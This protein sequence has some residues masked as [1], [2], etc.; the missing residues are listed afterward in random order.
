MPDDLVKSRQ[1]S[2][3]ER[4]RSN[5][6][7]ISPWKYGI[8]SSSRIGGTPRNDE[9]GTYYDSIMPNTGGKLL[10]RVFPPLSLLRKISFKGDE[11]IAFFAVENR[12]ALGDLDSKSE[13]SD[14][15]IPVLDD[16]GRFKPQSLNLGCLGD[17]EG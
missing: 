11:D 3:C 16:I 9:N 14:L 15:G 10:S 4:T 2:H 13:I 6:V 7:F 1:K 5:F 17:Q 12:H 8:A